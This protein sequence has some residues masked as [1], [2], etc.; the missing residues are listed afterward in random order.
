MKI[1]IEK[2]TSVLYNVD[3]LAGITGIGIGAIMGLF[4]FSETLS[5]VLA[6]T[7]I[8]GL[9]FAGLAMMLHSSQ[10]E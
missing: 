9:M 6:I 3:T 7:C 2:Y 1:D 8:F 10:S 4:F 5:D